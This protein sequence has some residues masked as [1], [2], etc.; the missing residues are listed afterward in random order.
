MLTAIA[1]YL[2]CYYD[3]GLLKKNRNITI[4]NFKQ[5]T[6]LTSPH[7]SLEFTKFHTSIIT[8]STFMWLLE[9]VTVSNVSNQFARCSERRIT[10]LALLRTN[11]RVSVDV[12]LE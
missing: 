3:D 9:R 8:F 10:L 6:K 12:V 1:F 4:N 7:V 11:A 5:L 2:Q